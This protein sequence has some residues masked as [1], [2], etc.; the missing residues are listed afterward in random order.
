MNAATGREIPR[1]VNKAT[2]AA[3]HIGHFGI[4]ARIALGT[5]HPATENSFPARDGFDDS[6]L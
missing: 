4:T 3:T 1:P 5:N 2:Y 6:I